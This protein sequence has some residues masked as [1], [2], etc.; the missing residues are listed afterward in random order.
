MLL[1]L[2]ATVQLLSTITLASLPHCL[3]VIK[4]LTA[5]ALVAAVH[6]Y[7]NL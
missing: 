2:L 4:V 7:K 5:C 3:L 1:L 6:E